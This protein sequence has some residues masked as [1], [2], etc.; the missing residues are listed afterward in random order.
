M[1]TIPIYVFDLARKEKLQKRIDENEELGFEKHKIESEDN[2]ICT[3]V[4]LNFD[5]YEFMGFWIDNDIHDE[6][7]SL[8]IVMYIGSHCFRTPHTET[9]E[10]I[11][12]DLLTKKY[13]NSYFNT[14]KKQT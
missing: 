11:L 12:K 6:T 8:D 10:A 2:N 13:E 9:K 14:V 3:L 7:Q 5:E 4:D 1:R